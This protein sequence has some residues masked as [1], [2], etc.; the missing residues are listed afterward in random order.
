MKTLAFI[1]SCILTGSILLASCEF[2]KSASKDFISGAV[3]TGDGISCDKITVETGG[4]PGK[5]N[6]FVY[7]ETVNLVFENVSGFQKEDGKTYPA[8]SLDLVKN[9]KDTV[10]SYA[11]LLSDIKEGTS[12]SPL[13]LQ[14]NFTAALPYNN[15]EQYKAHIH[16]WDK[17][18]K[19]SFTYEMPFTVKDAGLLTVESTGIGYSTIYL[20]NESQK[21]P[22]RTSEID[23]NDKIILLLEGIKGLSSENEKVYPIL[24]L[25]L[26]DQEGTKILDNPNLF[27]TYKEVGIKAEDV[28]RQLS[29]TITFSTGAV[30]NPYRLTAILS[31]QK[32]ANQIKVTTELKIK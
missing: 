17:K 30:K 14:A 21:Q 22:V 8:L 10:L 9:E 6:Q 18:G 11:D 19:G 24:S 1:S 12:L 4:Q 28:A 27:S 5:N 20:W 23:Q 29:A 25:E 31:D 26:L 3:S 15:D 13:E 16:I 7:G 2:N 32:S